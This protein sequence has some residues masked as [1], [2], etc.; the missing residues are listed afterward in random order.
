MTTVDEQAE[1]NMTQTAGSQVD[2][3][4]SVQ[5]LSVYFGGVKAVH[6]VSFAVPRGCIFG[7]LGTN[8]SGKSTLLAAVSRLL[9][10]TAGRL[11]LNGEDVTSVSPSRLAR[12]GVS[13]TF[14]TPRLVPTLNVRENVALAADRHAGVPWR[15][16]A[17]ATRDQVDEV[18]DLT[19][20]TGLQKLV[21]AQLSYGDARRAE[22]ARALAHD[23]TLLLLDEPTAG[24]NRMERDEVATMLSGLRDRGLT[25]VLIEHDVP[26]MVELCDVL[27]AMVGGIVVAHGNPRD[28]VAHPVVRDAYLGRRSHG[29]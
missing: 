14:Q 9:T 21:P 27:L 26:M 16:R 29:A 7:V 19:G 17:R 11:L 1:G 18:L 3:V 28:V 10:P 22:I 23:P 15:H 6:E 8:G 24:M 20:I 25:Q 4:L 2:E 13:R 12:K 5:G